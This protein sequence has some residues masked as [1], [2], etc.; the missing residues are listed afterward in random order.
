M[1]EGDVQT[2][3]TLTGLL[4]DQADALLRYFCKTFG[5]TVLYTEGYM[6][7]TFVAFVEPF[8]NGALR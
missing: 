6:V 4:V 5:Y 3:S 8:L 1:E 2:L 7:Y